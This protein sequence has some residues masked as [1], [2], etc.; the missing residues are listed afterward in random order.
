MAVRVRQVLTTAC[1][2]GNL[3]Y[4]VDLRTRI[5]QAYKAGGES[6]ASVAERFSVSKSSVRRYVLQWQNGGDLTPKQYT[7]GPKPVISGEE[8]P[9][10]EAWL[11]E[12]SSL[13]QNEL[14]KRYAQHT[15]RS[16]S[17]Q[18]VCRAL[19]RAGFTYKKRVSG[20]VNR[21]ERT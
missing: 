18:T 9:L 6:F 1:D 12:E 3:A 2:G 20:P 16:I 4:S 7:P 21:T 8:L 13:T 14:A 15:G 19:S 17:Q 5:V 10:F 11:Q